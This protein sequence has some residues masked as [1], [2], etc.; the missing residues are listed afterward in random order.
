S[1]RR[2]YEFEGFRLNPAERLLTHHGAPVPLAPKAFEMLVVLVSNSGRLLTKDELMR[3]VWAD[4]VVE[5]NNLDKTIS[6]LRKALGENGAERKLIETVRGH[7]YR[8][9][10]AV[11]EIVAD[12]NSGALRMIATEPRDPAVLSIIPPLPTLP[13]LDDAPTNV[14]TSLPSPV[15]IRDKEL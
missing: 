15:E 10:A 7:G 2:L 6:A 4:A 9:N 3:A 13:H 12:Q 1:A 14:R 11:T 8:F 5:E